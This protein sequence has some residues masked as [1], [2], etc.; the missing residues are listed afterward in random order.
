MCCYLPLKPTLGGAKGYIEVAQN[1]RR[2]G[3]N[4]DLVGIDT[5]VGLDQPYMSE[6]WRLVNFPGKLRDYLLV[7]SKKYDVVEYESLYLPFSVKNEV[8]CLLAVR[9]SLL[10]LNFLQIKIP[11][12]KGLRAMAG[13]LF[14]SW[15]RKKKLNNKIKQSL[16]SM[17]SADLINVQ[18]PTDKELLIKYKFSAD[19]IIVQPLGMFEDKYTQYNKIKLDKNTGLVRKTIVFVGTFDNRKGAVEFPLIIK[20][21]L[22]KHHDVDFKL[23]GV[24]GMFPTE[25]SVYEYIGNEFRDRVHI[26]GRFQPDEL[27]LLLNDCS[28]GIFPSYLESFGYGV[29]E[30]MTMGLPVVGYN[31][32]GINM[33]LLE[34]LKVQPGD[35]DQMVSIFSRLITDH[36]FA[37][38]CSEKCEAKVKLFIYE[39]QENL[40]IKTYQEK[41]LKSRSA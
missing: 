19:K 32:P 12:F 26:Q 7:H 34:E 4:V 5:I 37:L 30:M 24:L 9:C 10:D 25:E 23:L 36:K 40:S 20:K 2:L 35:I 16:K 3:H 27:P 6:E 8:D 38:D 33:L 1:Y 41:I 21:I 11:K 28:Y 29:L 14:K 15:S 22:T 18:N 39:N 31:S 13:F 17:D